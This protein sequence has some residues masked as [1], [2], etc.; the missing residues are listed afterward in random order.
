MYASY[1]LGVRR[2]TEEQGGA[3]PRIVRNAGE[4]AD[5]RWGAHTFFLSPFLFFSFFHRDTIYILYRKKREAFASSFFFFRVCA[6]SCVCLY[7]TIAQLA[8]PWPEIETKALLI[9][10]FF[11]FRPL[12]GRSERE[13]IYTGA[14]QTSGFVYLPLSS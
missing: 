8:R 3:E 4:H 9:L 7:K 13:R 2:A 6:C 1:R 10:L 5:V 12:D 11:L 14:E